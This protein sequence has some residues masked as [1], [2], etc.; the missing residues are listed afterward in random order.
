M[1]GISRKQSGYPRVSGLGFP[2]F[3]K[4]NDCVVC[5][6][7]KPLAALRPCGH[8]CVCTSCAA[9]LSECP[10]CSRAVAASQTDLLD[11]AEADSSSSQLMRA[12]KE[13]SRSEADEQVRTAKPMG[14]ANGLD[15]AEADLGKKTLQ[16]SR[17]SD[18]AILDSEES[19]ISSRLLRGVRR[20]NLVQEV[21]TDLSLRLRK[22][23]EPSTMFSMS[24]MHTSDLLPPMRDQ[25]SSFMPAN[26]TR[27]RDI[28]RSLK[29]TERSLP[30]ND[31]H[32]AKATLNESASGPEKAPFYQ[33]DVPS[34]S[35]T[36]P[37]EPS[38][39]LH[40]RR[41]REVEGG[42]AAGDATGINTR[43]IAGLSNKT[44]HAS[45][46]SGALQAP[47]S[48]AP[49]GSPL[50]P[51]AEDR[52]LL[53]G[54]SSLFNLTRNATFCPKGNT[55]EESIFYIPE[56]QQ[57]HSLVA[58]GHLVPR[59]GGRGAEALVRADAAGGPAPA[60]A[61]TSMLSFARNARF[62]QRCEGTNF[63]ESES[64]RSLSAI[65][66][67]AEVRAPSVAPFSDSVSCLKAREIG[68]RVQSA[69]S[70]PKRIW[71]D[72]DDQR[73][74]PATQSYQYPRTYQ[75]QQEPQQE[76]QGPLL[77]ERGSLYT[78]HRAASRA[79]ADVIAGGDG[80]C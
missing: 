46:A 64:L 62:A 14:L 22:P 34:S 15:S 67:V 39:W 26:L 12:N 55:S 47:A 41:I 38:L 80:Q 10:V 73:L 6:V 24:T 60:L 63:G 57:Q 29:Q 52:G 20:Q 7:G 32:I 79:T 25:T 42:S 75:P 13:R 36:F 51:P 74:Q 77:P 58:G 33:T 21:T 40:T 59:R 8:Q 31:V 35:K 66:R 27:L 54:M 23:E 61:D 45:G 65:G 3:G 44:R 49:L 43:R 70:A 78:T 68:C 11:S 71:L 9:Y 18:T 30:S 50:S 69:A 19:V 37:K 17:T 2:T 4:C 1:N 48:T 56:Q 16:K 72:V 28:R 53:D 76:P 5:K